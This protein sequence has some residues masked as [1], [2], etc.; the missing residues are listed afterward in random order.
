MANKELVQGELVKRITLKT[1]DLYIFEA[2]D[3]LYLTSPYYCQPPSG[4]LRVGEMTL[5]DKNQS[6]PYI[7]PEINL[8]DPT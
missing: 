3:G 5:F 4:N 2:P 1:D 6:Q 8:S 7:M